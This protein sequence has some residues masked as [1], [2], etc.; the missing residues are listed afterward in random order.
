[1][2]SVSCASIH[3]KMGTHITK[4]YVDSAYA[5]RFP[6]STDTRAVRVLPW[7][8]GARIKSKSDIVIVSRGQ[9]ILI[10][11]TQGYEGE[12]KHQVQRAV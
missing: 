5:C 11:F 4:V 1:M 6:G 12:G 7:M 2:D 9:L 10:R 3:R 8:S